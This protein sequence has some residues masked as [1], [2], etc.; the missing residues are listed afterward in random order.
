MQ[1]SEIALI[2][3]LSNS[4]N[5]TKF[6]ETKHAKIGP[7]QNLKTT[8]S[9]VPCG[10]AGLIS[11]P[12]SNPFAS[13]VISVTLTRWTKRSHSG[14]LLMAR[15]GVNS[16]ATPNT[17]LSHS[18]Y[19]QGVPS[20]LF[21]DMLHWCFFFFSGKEEKSLWS[22]DY[23]MLSDYL[24]LS[25]TERTQALLFCQFSSDKLCRFSERREDA[26]RETRMGVVTVYL[27]R[28]HR[29]EVFF[30]LVDIFGLK[31]VDRHH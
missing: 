22:S 13:F 3:G 4:L 25:F 12:L 16:L 21:C 6:K 11:S 31:Q 23:L 5:L 17:A 19:H 29:F 28:S 8:C 1:K 14:A 20:L 10:D 2:L 15:P 18:F 27:G 7:A 24:S 30:P 9:A 26:L